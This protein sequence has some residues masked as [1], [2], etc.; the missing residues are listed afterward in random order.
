MMGNEACNPVSV[1][2]QAASQKAG[3]G[4]SLEPERKGWYFGRGIEVTLEEASV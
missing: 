2:S 4:Q 3:P 1:D